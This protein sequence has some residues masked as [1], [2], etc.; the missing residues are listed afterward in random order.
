MKR[1]REFLRSKKD[2]SYEV[3][4]EIPFEVLVLI[5]IAILLA[6]AWWVS[7]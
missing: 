6:L 2:G 5:S 3:E 1:F 7:L 4:I